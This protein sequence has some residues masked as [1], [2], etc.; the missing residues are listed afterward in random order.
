MTS[1]SQSERYTT[2]AIILHWLIALAIILMLA[3]GWYMTNLPD[4]APGQYELYQLHKSVGITILLL[5]ITRIIW[6]VMNPPPALPADMNEQEKTASH[7]VH[8]AFYGL[9]IVLPLTGWLYSSVSTKLDVPTVLYGV[10]SWP[11]VPYAEAMK[12]GLISSIA[13]TS[14]T[15]LALLAVATL[16]LHLGGALKH[17]FSAE[18][19]VI[20]RMLPSGILGKT[21]TPSAR[22]RGTL[23]AF[24]SAIAALVFVTGAPGVVTAL[25]SD[26]AAFAAGSGI[27]ANWTV[28]YD[29]SEIRFS[30]VHDGND[31]TG[32]FQNWDAAIQFDPDAPEDADVE[33]TVSTASARASQK[34]YT[35]SLPSPEWLNVG[36]FPTAT[37]Q[38]VDITGI[39]DRAY[40]GAAR[41]TLKDIT[42]EREFQ[43]VLDIEGDTATMTGQTILQRAPLDLGQDSDPDADW[44]S[45]DVTVDVTVV[46]TR[47]D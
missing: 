5:T 38:I 46:A 39:K 17:E 35:D 14:H 1:A 13:N 41:L 26:G 30:G 24:G 4:G 19:G 33:V 34:L 32:T 43:F 44:V 22:G 8:M 3:G 37:V 10:L 29:Q 31:Y 27:K 47:L 40:T 25:S 15:V 11:D 45:E 9:M 28:D 12:T 2:V 7:L 42:I 20:K 18:E 16:A 6:R 36:A 23:V 21:K